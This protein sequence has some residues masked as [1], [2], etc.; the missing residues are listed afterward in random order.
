MKVLRALRSGALLIAALCA[1]APVD[2]QGTGIIGGVVSDESG[3]VL[4]GAR[5]SVS[6]VDGVYR[7]V[8]STKGDGTFSLSGV[9]L[10]RYRVQVESGL[11]EAGHADV[12]LTDANARVDL[13]ITLKVRGFG[14]NVTVS[15]VT[16][17]ERSVQDLPAS[18]SVVPA[19]RLFETPGLAID[20]VLRTVPSVDLGRVSSY[21]Q[22]PTSNN[23]SIRGLL[24]GVISRMLVTV[25]GVPVN[26]PFSGWVQWSRVPEDLVRRIEVLRGG[27]ST[28]WGT[29]ATSGVVNIVTREPNDRELSGDVAY[30]G[31]NTFRLNAFG[32]RKVSQ[33]F[34]LAGNANW[35]TTDGFN[36]VPEDQR[37]P[38]DVPTSFDAVHLNLQANFRVDP[39]LSGFVRGQFFHD[40]Q[41]L[42]TPAAG[43]HQNSGDASG[44]LT[45]TFEGGRL[46]TTRAYYHKGIFVTD[47]VGTP[48]GSETRFAEFVQNRHTTDATDYGVSVQHS[49]RLT[50]SVPQLAFGVDYHEVNGRDDGDIFAE[51]GQFVRTDVG[52]GKQR[53]IGAYGLV[54]IAPTPALEVLGS[55]RWDYW[56]NFDGFDGTT[57]H[58][59]VPAKTADAISPR[60]GT[61]Y[62]LTS[63]VGVRAA[64]Y[65]SF[66]A[67]T[68]DNLYRAF[69]TPGYVGLPNSQLDP[70][71]ARG[72]E[73]GLD[74]I[75]ARTRLQV[76]WFS[77]TVRDEI[78]SRN[79]DPSESIF[80]PGFDFASLNIN[81]G[82]LRSRGIEAE[83]TR[84]IRSEFRVD[85]GYTFAD[86]VITDNPLDPSSVGQQSQGVPRHALNVGVAYEPPRG[87]GVAG[88]MRWT[89]TYAALFSGNTLG[90][91]AVVDVSGRYVVS[92]RVVL[93]VNVEN[94]FNKFYIADDNGFLPTQ[95]GM[96]FHVVA[97][98]RTALR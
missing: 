92:S 6:A 87:L 24:S 59:V 8:V 93:Y 38:L 43:N 96:P 49:Q 68:L 81:A 55:I 73:I 15:A 37:R 80:P 66:N 18:I 14:E 45:K 20:D 33:G 85:G 11:F 89:S 90:R 84:A 83:L 34:T 46:L 13:K 16:R 77:R 88:R 95:R 51:T 98:V 61:R 67:P 50:A 19:V 48:D 31:L 91:A 4:E 52:S 76:T 3:G 47:N 23:P 63:S 72:G 82:K 42:G 30:G 41:T 79:V 1:A 86:S 32:A 53:G 29:F 94:L 22:H 9:P 5:V 21:A 2:A 71:R 70:E 56:R 62:R 54:T 60:L 57:G 65:G 40:Q 64:A 97:G 17:T 44:G 27:G 36:Q 7:Q 69:S 75:D 58:G 39:T 26:D 28:V 35:Y 78:T 12:V 74:L 10:G 25:D